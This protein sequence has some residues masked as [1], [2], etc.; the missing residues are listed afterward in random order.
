MKNKKVEI[1]GCDFNNGSES[2]VG[3]VGVVSK[4]IKSGWCEGCVEVK[5]S[6]GDKEVFFKD[7][8]KFL[9]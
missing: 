8:V 9:S 4:V 2:W 7:D 1:V 6:D 3:K 5:F